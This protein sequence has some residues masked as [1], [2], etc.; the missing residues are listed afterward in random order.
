MAITGYA[1]VF[2]QV[3]LFLKKMRLMVAVAAGTAAV[4]GVKAFAVLAL[5]SGSGVNAAAA[6]KPASC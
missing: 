4:A 5:L 1:F 6:A 3:Q 2:L